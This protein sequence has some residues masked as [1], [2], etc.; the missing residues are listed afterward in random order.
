MNEKLGNGNYEVSID[1]ITLEVSHNID[2]SKIN[3]KYSEDQFFSCFFYCKTN[4][5]SEFKKIVF[6]S[7][8][9]EINIGWLIPSYY[10]YE[11]EEFYEEEGTKFL[12][13]F[14]Y[15]G[16]EIFMKRGFDR[17]FLNK[18]LSSSQLS[19]SVGFQD[20]ID[21]NIYILVI[22][23][24]FFKK[25]KLSIKELEFLLQLRGVYK[26]D[27]S[28]DID[29]FSG[30]SLPDKVEDLGFLIYSSQS[31]NIR[32]K[33]N[34]TLFV[35]YYD[36]LFNIFD[37]TLKSIYDI[38][39]YLTSYQI[40]E[41]LMEHMLER[42]IHEIDFNGIKSWDLKDKLANITSE[43][44]R[45]SWIRECVENNGGD[46]HIF[47]DLKIKLNN[48]MLRL[49]QQETEKKEWIE[50]VYKLRNIIVHNQLLI[51][52]K[53]IESDFYAINSRFLKSVAEIIKCYL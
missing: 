11:P 51:Y 29:Y 9:S 27:D 52:R 36:V 3:V 16:Y 8:G 37:K 31:K 2:L 12:V 34:H 32:I 53:K 38:S 14:A 35:E 6:E 20:F 46:K 10:Y 44:K 19:G 47:N 39:S 28:F 26:I 45:L 18:N 30:F 24:E 22:S 7:E 50:L 17:K 40:L 25:T 4:N 49:E 21:E 13:D 41:L 33:K 23:K 42:K 1:E 5:S 43:K 15:A 48:T